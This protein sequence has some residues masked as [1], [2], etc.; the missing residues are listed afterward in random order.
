MDT[1][2]IAVTL[3]SLGIAGA[4]GVLLTRM[5]REERRRSD[6]R[7]T[8]LMDLADSNEPRSQ[9]TAHFTDL[10]LHPDSGSAAVGDLFHEH[11]AQPA[12][13]RR[14][15]AAGATAVVIGTVILGWSTL[16]RHKSVG[17]PAAEASVARPPLELLSLSHKQ[18]RETLIISGLVQ[19]PRGASVLSGVRAT[20]LVFGADGAMIASGRTPLDFTT[21]AAGDESPFV[22]RVAATGAARY[23]IGFRGAQ[24]EMLA[25]VDR[26]NPDTLARK[27]AP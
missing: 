3:A 10:E 17:A 20:V 25:H 5:A 15:F 2:L 18:E 27:E 6:A 11:D 1:L 23:R 19:N 22:I 8:L 16:D 26:R 4:L 13:P 24:D 9:T 7:V 12:W 21:L 14:L